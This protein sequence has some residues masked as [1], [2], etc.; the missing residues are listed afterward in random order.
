MTGAPLLFCEQSRIL[1]G[2]SELAGHG[3]HDLEIPRQELRFALRAQC[4]H[5]TSGPSA[6]KD[7]YSTE[8]ASG[9]RRDEIDPELYSHCFEIVLDQQGLA[10]PED[11]LG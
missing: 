10:G 4:C 1:D 5:H 11:V 7:R 6:E 8:R 3:L 9:M 2:Y